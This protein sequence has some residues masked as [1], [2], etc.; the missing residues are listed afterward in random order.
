MIG[1]VLVKVAK[2]LKAAHREERSCSGLHHMNKFGRCI[3][4]TK[5]VTGT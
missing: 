5:P 1:N 4:N 3:H 2:S